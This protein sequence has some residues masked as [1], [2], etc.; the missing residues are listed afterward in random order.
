MARTAQSPVRRHAAHAAL[1]ALLAAAG[2]AG[3]QPTADSAWAALQDGTIVLLRHAQAPGVGDPSG[4]KLGDCSTQRNLSEAGRAQAR[5]IGERFRTQGVAVGAVLTSQWCRTRDTA[6][7]AFPG[8]ARDDPDFNSFFGDG[9]REAA[10]SAAAAAT[11]SRWRGPGVMVVVTHQV[12]ITALTG[13]VP[14]SGEAV[15][16]RPKAGGIE[17]VGRLHP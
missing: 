4:F 17:V 7:L 9:A 13:I 8:Q 15:V 1:A 14:A 12:N 6:E 11:L 16:V 5:G 3:A 2:L 10:Q